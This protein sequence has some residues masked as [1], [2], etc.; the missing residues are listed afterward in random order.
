MSASTTWNSQIA[1]TFPLPLSFYVCNGHKQFYTS[2]VWNAR[3]YP[4][5]PNLADKFL[6]PPPQMGLIVPFFCVP[7][8]R[9]ALITNSGKCRHQNARF[10]M[11]HPSIDRLTAG[12]PLAAVQGSSPDKKTGAP[13]TV[14]AYGIKRPRFPFVT[15]I[16]GGPRPRRTAA[17]SHSIHA[18]RASS[19]YRRW[20]ETPRVFIILN[21]L[22]LQTNYSKTYFLNLNLLVKP[23]CLTWPKV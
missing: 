3:F 17:K 7:G 10:I 12:R 16:S 5:S 11:P 21:L 22:F 20:G 2:T 4:A 14:V 23:A 6:P 1:V 15:A 18:G 9:T 8:R 19:E 13:R